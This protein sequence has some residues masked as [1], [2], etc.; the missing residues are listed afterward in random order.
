MKTKRILVGAVSVSLLASIAACKTA[1]RRSIAQEAA[2]VASTSVE[3]LVCSDYTLKGPSWSR[4]NDLYARVIAGVQAQRARLVTA[5]AETSPIRGW[6]SGSGTMEEFRAQLITIETQ[7]REQR[8]A[9]CPAGNEAS[10]KTSSKDCLET[11]N[12]VPEY[13]ALAQQSRYL[14]TR[15]LE[16]DL[17]GVH[18]VLRTGMEGLG[19]NVTAPVADQALN[20]EQTLGFL[21]A[22]RGARASTSAI[23]PGQGGGN[24]RRHRTAEGALEEYLARLDEGLSRVCSVPAEETTPA[25]QQQPA[26][27]SASEDSPVGYAEPTESSDSH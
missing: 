7:L 17:L 26:A 20:G 10:S 6:D 4:L 18:S 12:R 11:L 1:G 27:S 8:E 9:A 21:R 3:G 24:H 16:S 15:I 25:E 2:D 19:L 14:D 13:A 5:S 23:I 22:L